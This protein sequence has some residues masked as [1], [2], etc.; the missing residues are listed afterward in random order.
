MKNQVDS[1]LQQS[2]VALEMQKGYIES[3]TNQIEMIQ[4]AM[5]EHVKAKETLSQY[6]KLKE[7][8]ELLVPIGA[9]SFIYAKKTKAK[10][11]IIGIGANVTIEEDLDKAVERI[12]NKLQNLQKTGDELTQQ[13][14]NVQQQ[15]T[16]LSEKIRKEMEGQ[17]NVQKTKRET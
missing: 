8:N 14:A 16:A 4:L 6:M 10:K 15:A 1:K 11:A 17:Q 3:L 12:E 13:L 5:N 9:N 2:M 7:G